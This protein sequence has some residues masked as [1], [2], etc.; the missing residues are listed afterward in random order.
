MEESRKS[1]PEI[2]E[3]ICIKEWVDSRVRMR[4]NDGEINDGWIQHA[5]MTE[6]VQAVY[7][8]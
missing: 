7:C 5:V 8:V 3:M 6:C 1:P 2:L 4:K